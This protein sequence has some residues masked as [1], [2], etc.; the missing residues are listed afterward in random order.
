[1]RLLRSEIERAGGQIHWAKIEG[2]SRPHLNKMLQGTRQLSKSIIKALKIRIVYAPAPESIGV[3]RDIPLRSSPSRKA[4][5][6]KGSPI[7]QR[8]SSEKERLIEPAP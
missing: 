8:N 4:S 3:A 2:V 1:M 5:R 7:S 6:E